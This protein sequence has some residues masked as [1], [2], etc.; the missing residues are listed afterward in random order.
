MLT[1]HYERPS[2]TPSHTNPDAN[3]ETPSNQRQS[4]SPLQMSRMNLMNIGMSDARTL[5][6]EKDEHVRDGRP[7]IWQMGDIGKSQ[8]VRERPEKTRAAEEG[9]R[10][11]RIWN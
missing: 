10:G 2:I 3:P 1:N 4:Q 8:V 11:Y 7:P 9:R 6:L 5:A